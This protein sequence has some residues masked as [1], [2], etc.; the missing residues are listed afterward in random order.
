M[1]WASSSAPLC[2]SPPCSQPVQPCSCAL[3]AAPQAG[4]ASPPRAL[5]VFFLPA[6]QVLPQRAPDAAGAE[7]GAGLPVPECEFCVCESG[8]A[9]ASGLPGSPPSAAPLWGMSHPAPAP[10]PGHRWPLVSPHTGQSCPLFALWA[11]GIPLEFPVG[12]ACFCP[13]LAAG[14]AAKAQNSLLWHPGCAE[15]IPD[16]AEEQGGL[17]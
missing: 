4:S 16:R 13:P 8:T 9:L 17:P 3:P 5:S 10:A 14:A 11:W 12:S 15:E 6:A 7:G 1:A 2:L